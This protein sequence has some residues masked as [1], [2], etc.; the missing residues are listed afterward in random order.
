LVII[1][2]KQFI[3]FFGHLQYSLVYNCM[4]QVLSWVFGRAATKKAADSFTIC[5]FFCAVALRR[6][7][8]RLAPAPRAP[9][10]QR[11]ASA[12]IA[13]AGAPARTMVRAGAPCG[14]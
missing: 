10:E 6:T 2:C 11:G 8:V 7:M 14:V 12:S 1:E 3:C 4:I 5:C 9:S 13:L